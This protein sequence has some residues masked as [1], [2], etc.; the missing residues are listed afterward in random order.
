[1]YCRTTHY[2]LLRPALVHL[3]VQCRYQTEQRG[4]LNTD[5]QEFLRGF[6]NS[7]SLVPRLPEID[8]LSRHINKRFLVHAIAYISKKL[9]LQYQ[10]R[11]KCNTFPE[12]LLFW[13]K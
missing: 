13:Q 12:A 1:M 6:L 3:A 4:V 8:S 7:D 2:Q 5:G 10:R 9:I 11:N